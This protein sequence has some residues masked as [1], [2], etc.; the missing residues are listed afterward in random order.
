MELVKLIQK[1]MI[2]E[3]V[4]GNKELEKLSGVG[5]GVILRLLSGS[6]STKQKDV[7]AITS[8]LK[9]NTSYSIQGEDQ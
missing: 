9:I 1:Q 3:G 5:Y 7:D 8:V 4:G 6:N 2:E